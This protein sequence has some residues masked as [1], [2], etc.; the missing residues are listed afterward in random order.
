MTLSN[1]SNSET[2][3]ITQNG[4]PVIIRV[5]G[6]MFVLVL[7]FTAIANLLPQV[8]G[9]APR[10]TKVNLGSLTMESYIAMGEQLFKG[11][12]TCTL[13]HNNLGR[14][15]DILVMDMTATA[16]QR[17][18]S[19][20]YK[21]E[22]VD[23][24]SYIRESMIHPSQYIVPGFGKA[25]EPSPMPVINKA[26]VALSDLEMGAIIAFLQS[27]DG[28]QVT[29]ELPAD[30]PQQKQNS[31]SVSEQPKEAASAQEVLIKNGCIACHAVL[32]SQAEI[33]PELNTVGQRLS[34]EAIRESIINPSAVIAEGYPP[35]MPGDFADKMMVKE[36][37]MVVDF[38][39]GTGQSGV[40][41]AANK[42]VKMSDNI[43]QQGEQQQ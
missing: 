4:P 1:Q 36:L 14:A 8:E 23:A 37:E 9:Q 20:D 25:G 26:P 11:K 16:L 6:F 13:C 10:E 5:L 15:P 30:V 32:D 7:I 17:I 19:E 39:A 24:E 22:A 3:D 38:L 41:S 40:G 27:K 12:G 35:I 2:E 34:R 21:G 31:Q 28:G 18:K 43:Q 33:G 29:V 42:S